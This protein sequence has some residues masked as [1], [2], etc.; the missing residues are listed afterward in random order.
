MFSRT[1]LVLFYFVEHSFFVSCAH[2]R[3]GLRGVATKGLLHGESLVT[4][5]ALKTLLF[6]GGRF[7]LDLLGH[8]KWNKV[9]LSV[10]FLGINLVQVGETHF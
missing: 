4:V 10:L 3:V 8:R 7:F 1:H 6:F 2:V 5:F 9:R